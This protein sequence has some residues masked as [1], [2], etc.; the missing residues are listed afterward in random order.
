MR[1]VFHF[2]CDLGRDGGAKKMEDK[3]KVSLD[4]KQAC[5]LRPGTP[6]Y[7]VRSG[8]HFVCGWDNQEVSLDT[9][10]DLVTFRLLSSCFEPW[11]G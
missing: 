6:C 5:F 7:P 9:K 3:R 10:Q 4:A 11:G 2:V 8:V 1:S